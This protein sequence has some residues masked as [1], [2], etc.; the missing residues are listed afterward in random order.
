MNGKFRTI[1]V[2][3]MNSVLF[4]LLC[5]FVCFYSFSSPWLVDFYT[6]L[7]YSS[8]LAGGE[9]EYENVSCIDLPMG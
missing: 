6:R 9:W 8:I 4:L 1:S 5:S 7:I 3:D 2:T